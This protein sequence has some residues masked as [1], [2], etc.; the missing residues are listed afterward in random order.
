MAKFE[1]MFDPQHLR[2]LEADDYE[3]TE[4]G[5]LRVQRQFIGKNVFGQEAIGW[6]TVLDANARGWRWIRKLEGEEA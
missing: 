5:G 6:E 1:V 2:I 4:G 3:I